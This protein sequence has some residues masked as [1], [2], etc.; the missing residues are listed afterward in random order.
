MTATLT[1]G[2]ASLGLPDLVVDGTAPASEGYFIGAGGLAEPTFDVRS[3]YAPD[4]AYTPGSQLLAATLQA[5]TL[6]VVVVV[7]ANSTAALTTL[8]A[9]L[10][11]AAFQ[12]A[13][14]V[15][16]TVNGTAQ[17]FDAGPC[18][19]AWSGLTSALVDA[20]MVRATLAIPVQPTGV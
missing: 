3:T 6:P 17:V 14:T 15:T 13:Y 7:Q 12:F 19:P 4:S 20:H 11:Q 1:L 10:A 5:S 18:W 2:R 9:A 8:K 16:L